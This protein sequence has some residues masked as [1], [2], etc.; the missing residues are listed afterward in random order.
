M[1]F[2]CVFR[3]DLVDVTREALGN[4]V[5][6]YYYDMYNYYNLLDVSRFE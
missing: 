6:V 4:I 5:L 1:Y 2:V 3:H